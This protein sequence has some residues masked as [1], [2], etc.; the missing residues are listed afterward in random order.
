MR[1]DTRAARFRILC[2]R[3]AALRFGDD[4]AETYLAFDAAIYGLVTLL[5]GDTTGSSKSFRVIAQLLHGDVGLGILFT[6]LAVALALSALRLLS[7]VGRRIV[8]VATFAV[9]SGMAVGFFLGYPASLGPYV[10]LLNA[11]TA[12]VAY[13]RADR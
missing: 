6:V 5:P 7:D 8:L 11:L 1:A 13:L 4:W 9:W 12:W 10:A 2:V 3:V